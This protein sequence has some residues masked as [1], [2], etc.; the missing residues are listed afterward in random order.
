M[1]PQKYKRHSKRSSATELSGLSEDDLYGIS[2]TS[3]GSLLLLGV[4]PVSIING[5]LEKAGVYTHLEALGYSDF[6]LSL[7]SRDY[8]LQ[9]LALYSSSP[10]ENELLGEVVLKRNAAVPPMLVDALSDFYQ[11]EL[12]Q[13]EWLMFRHPLGEFSDARPPLPGQEFPGLGLGKA[14]LT[15]L[16]LLGRRCGAVGILNTPEYYHNAEM[17]ARAAYFV[18]PGYE[19]VRRRLS[20]QFLKKLGLSRLSWAIDSGC[21]LE[22]AQSFHWPIAPQLLP[23]HRKLRNFFRGRAYKKAVGA[24]MD[25]QAYFLDENCL[26][27]LHL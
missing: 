11:P 23:V 10:D 21:V 16:L 14:V 15:F 9:R 13:I 1:W 7:D 27:R 20:R 6:Y 8:Y 19:A 17:Y 3:G 22:N 26:K 2:D 5:Y 18:D 4:L 25:G 24:A 12:L